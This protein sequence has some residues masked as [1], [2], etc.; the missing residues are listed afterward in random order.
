MML[1]HFEAKK[2]F[3]PSKKQN[4]AKKSAVKFL[5][6][7]LSC[8]NFSLQMIKGNSVCFLLAFKKNSILK[9]TINIKKPM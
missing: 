1:L 7:M 8:K 6:T 3:K 2:A 5:V 4:R 9:R